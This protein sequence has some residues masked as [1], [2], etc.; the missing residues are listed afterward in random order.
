MIVGDSPRRRVG[1]GIFSPVYSPSGDLGNH[2][3]VFARFGALGL[4][5]V[6]LDIVCRGCGKLSGNCNLG[7]VYVR[8]QHELGC[9]SL[10]VPGDTKDDP[11]QTKER[12]HAMNVV[13]STI[14]DTSKCAT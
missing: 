9:A 12:Q 8:S 1:N 7:S 4:I 2:S 6:V 13:Y 11:E 14:E 5:R 3:S 10:S